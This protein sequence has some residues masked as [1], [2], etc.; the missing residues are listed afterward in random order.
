MSKLDGITEKVGGRSA[1]PPTENFPLLV[2]GYG[3]DGQNR[4]IVK[5]MRLDT[6]DEISVALRA[7]RGPTLKAPRAEVK[8]FV[9]AEGEISA[10]MKSLP[11]DEMRRQVLK[12]IKAKTEPGG[13]IIVQ[14]AYTESK[15]GIVNAGW[16]QSAAKYADHCKVAPNVMVRVDPPVHKRD[17]ERETSSA[18]ATVIAPQKAQL[19]KSEDEFKDAL[20]AAFEGLEDVKGRPIA[21]VRVSD[22][23]N[24][25]AIEYPLPV[26]R[27]PDYAEDKTQPQ[28]LTAT[29]GQA[30]AKFLQDQ[31]EQFK[32][33][34]GDPDLKIEVIP[35]TRVQIGPQAKASF[36]NKNDGL[37]AVNAA[38]RFVK[39]DP[40]EAGF[41]PSYM[42]LHAVGEKQVFSAVELLSNKPALYHPRDVA[43]SAYQ[44]K[45]T[46]T[47][48]SKAE[49]AQPVAVET[50]SPADAAPADDEEEFE[51][52]DAVAASAPTSAPRPRP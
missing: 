35:G 11:T 38:Y 37:D 34:I 44:G 1:L 47:Q 41:T 20:K 6:G 30:A 46:V 22:G 5:G 48:E 7:Y 8:D 27:N 2:T 51:V 28:Y 16:L 42:I 25:K 50:A 21:L 3:Q 31:G 4:D 52:A 12:G 24:A 9:A 43:T 29:L 19:V 26:K 45:P 32:A 40:K 17:G 10:I 49:V 18:S 14:R 13:T 39:D 15:T 33:L 36:E 23:T